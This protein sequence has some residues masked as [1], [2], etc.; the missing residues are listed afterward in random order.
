MIVEERDIIPASQQKKRSAIK[1]WR[2]WIGIA[3][4]LF[5]LWLALRNVNLEEMTNLMKQVSLLYLAAAVLSYVLSVFAKSARWQ[6]LLSAHKS[7]AFARTFSIFSVGQMI[8]SFVPG[9]LGEVARAY[10]M[11][12]AEEDSKVYV[13]GTVVVERIADMFFL[14]ISL[15]ILLSQMTLPDWL[16]SPVRG[17]E[18]VLAILIPCFIL[19]AWQKNLVLR[20]ANWSGRLLPGRWRD[21]FIREAHFALDSLDA[22]RRPRLL[23]GLLFWSGLVYFFSTL[24]NYLVFLAFGIA[25]PFWAALLLLVVLQ[26]GTQIPSSAGGVGIVQYLI[27]LTLSLF[28]IG[29]NLALSYSILLYLV[30]SVPIVFIGGYSLWH[31]KIT[32]QELQKAATVFARMKNRPKSKT[33]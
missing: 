11:G 22:V 5:F 33:A 13:L 1:N 24:T 32:W 15:V 3:F 8:N 26:V 30:V 21:W 14:L 29:K 20:I 7:P 12:E 27:I 17:T 31:E 9:P 28:G 25:L 10:L 23:V 18:I 19:L 2:M 4:S 6:V 16:V